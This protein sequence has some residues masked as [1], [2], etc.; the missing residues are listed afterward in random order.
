[1]ETS[2]PDER[3]ILLRQMQEMI[4]GDYVNGYLFQLAKTG[5]ANA[6]IEGLWENS[7][8]QANDLTGVRW[9]Q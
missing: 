3:S 9:T 4:A 8:T 2:D 5:V 7:P 6:N 1:M